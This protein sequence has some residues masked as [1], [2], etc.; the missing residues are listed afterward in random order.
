MS[1]EQLLQK[2]DIIRTPR[3]YFASV[4]AD[5]GDSVVAS[6][7]GG[8][9]SGLSSFNFRKSEIKI[10]RT[11]TQDFFK[12]TFKS[13]EREE[14]RRVIAE[15]RELRKAAPTLES[16]IVRKRN[17]IKGLLKDLNADDERALVEFI[18]A[19]R[20]TKINGGNEV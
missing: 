8:S 4:I 17:N 10:V 15:E 19:K 18:K 16:K 6:W 20:L 7:I 1:K 2:N 13:I 9:F 14:L 11:N 3:G 5:S 12:S